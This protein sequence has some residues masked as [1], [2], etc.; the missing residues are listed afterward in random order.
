MSE[1]DDRERDDYTPPE[2]LKSSWLRD[3]LVVIRD[4]VDS[5]QIDLHL[6][7]VATARQ[8]LKDGKDASGLGDRIGQLHQKYPELIA[9]VANPELQQFIGWALDDDPL[10]FASLNFDR[11]TQQ[12]SHVDLIYF[13]TEPLHAMVG[14]WVALEDVS[15][16]AGPLFY[17]LG[18][19]QW[20]F[21]Y[22][23]TEYTDNEDTDH[24]EI[25]LN[26]RAKAWLDALGETI[27][28]KDSQKVPM[29]LR[30]GDVAIWHAKLAHG[31]MPRLNPALSRKSVVYHFIGKHSKLYSF[32]DFFTYEKDTLLR[33]EGVKVPVDERNGILYQVHPYFVTYDGGAEILHPL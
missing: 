4:A 21:E 31:G 7:T 28:K 33:R 27:R 30:K 2:A 11:G 22:P 8:D 13:C 20:N 19:H 32:S 23:G 26:G 10:L 24:R 17:H 15:L 16:D 14:A 29:S 9:T 12:E 1:L 6:A 18:S 25:D 5:E 3:G